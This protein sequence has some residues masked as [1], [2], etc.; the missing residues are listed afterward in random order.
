MARKRKNHDHE[1]HVDES[2]LIP[3]ADLLTLL[4]ALFIVLF[5][6]SSIDAAK[7]EQMAKSFNVVFTGGTGVMDQSS[8]QSTEETE[9]SNQTKKSAE[10]EEEEAKAKARDQ[11]VLTKVKKQVDSFIAD[12]K[13]GSKLETKLT[14]EGLLITIEDSIFFDSGRAVIRSQDVPLAKEISKLL[15]I[16]PA[17][18][19]VISG[20]TDNVPIRNS[21]FESNWYLSAIRAVNFLNILLEN[22]NLD[23]ENFSTKGYGEF[24]PIA[25]NDTAEGRSKNRRVEVL[26]LPIE[27]K[28]K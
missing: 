22:S 25:S 9:N 3:Y 26:I 27:K 17:R 18:D 15:V 13:L 21:E 11:A 7:Y 10:D 1:D 4:L 2:W 24:K 28:A 20:H 12:K 23:Q 6:S 16:N 8:M 14:D 19:I 5:A